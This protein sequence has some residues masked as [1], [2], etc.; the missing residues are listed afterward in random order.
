MEFYMLKKLN[1]RE[2]SIVDLTTLTIYL[3]EKGTKKTFE[4][5][6]ELKEEIIRLQEKGFHYERY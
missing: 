6:V 3:L 5:L 2:I 1:P 4:T